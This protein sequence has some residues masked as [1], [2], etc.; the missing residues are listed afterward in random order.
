MKPASFP[1]SD[2][3]PRF[4]LVTEKDGVSTWE[5]EGPPGHHLI[6]IST[7]EEEGLRREY[8]FLSQGTHPNLPKALRFEEVGGQWILVREYVPGEPLSK[9][10]GRLSPA[11]AGRIAAQA[12]R[13]LAAL[14]FRGF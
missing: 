2:L 5:S 7:R 11:E 3:Y 13:A 1:L 8:D 14:H 10:F 9:Y 12:A 6:K 4:R